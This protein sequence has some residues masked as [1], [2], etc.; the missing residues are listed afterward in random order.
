MQNTQLIDGYGGDHGLP[1]QLI[2][3]N[4]LLRSLK[5]IRQKYFAFEGQAAYAGIICPRT[6][7][8]RSS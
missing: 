5:I 3:S 2:D 4:D 7:L 1:A 6:V 8:W